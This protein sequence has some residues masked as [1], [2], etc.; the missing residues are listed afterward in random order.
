MAQDPMTEVLAEIDKVRAALV[1]LH[2]RM[3][4]ARRKH[5]WQIMNS[6]IEQ[7]EKLL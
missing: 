1:E 2:I 3:K 4:T 7:L 5:D 6:C